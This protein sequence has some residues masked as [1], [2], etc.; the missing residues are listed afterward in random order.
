MPDEMF[1]GGF[2]DSV[3]RIKE[4]LKDPVK[5]QEYIDGVND[6][7]EKYRQDPDIMRFPFYRPAKVMDRVSELQLPRTEY[8]AVPGFSFSSKRF[9]TALYQ[10]FIV[11]RTEAASLMLRISFHKTMIKSQESII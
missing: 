1:K 5:L 9:I 11:T 8:T 2:P 3:K 6:L 4:A 10:G 7:A